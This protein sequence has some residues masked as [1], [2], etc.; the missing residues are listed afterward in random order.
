MYL[1]SSPVKPPLK[2]ACKV[3]NMLKFTVSQ[4]EESFAFHF[5][6]LKTGLDSVSIFLSLSSH[7]VSP[8]P[9]NTGCLLESSLHVP[10]QAQLSLLQP[11]WCSCWSSGDKGPPFSTFSRCLCL[12]PSFHRAS[13]SHPGHGSD[14]TSSPLVTP[15]EKP[16]SHS[17]IAV[18]T[19]CPLL[20]AEVC[21]NRDFVLSPVACLPHRERLP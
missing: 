7:Q 4:G 13:R 11:R 21:N 20:P 3:T 15:L 19:V 1:V 10:F 9:S 8:F 12:E 2:L 17:F 5:P 6:L 14:C 16:V 18:L